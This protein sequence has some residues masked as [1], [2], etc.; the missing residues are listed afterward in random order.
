MQSPVH[1]HRPFGA[2]LGRAKLAGQTSLPLLPRLCCGCWHWE[3]GR[4]LTQA[5]RHGRA[6]PDL[7]PPQLF[8]VS[9]EL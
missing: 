7:V 1:S 3:Q 5:A 8:L 2:W 9:Q 4:N 6:W